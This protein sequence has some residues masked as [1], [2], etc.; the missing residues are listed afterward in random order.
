MK[1]ATL[2][3]IALYSLSTLAATNKLT[4]TKWYL[5]NVTKN[6]MTRIADT[7]CH[8]SIYF[9]ED[10]KYYGYSGMNN[11][12]GKYDITSERSL[13]MNIP[14]STRRYGPPNCILGESLYE[15]F[16]KVNRYILE[17]DHLVLFTIDS[18]RIVYRKEK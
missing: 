9:D 17:E 1:R 10:G 4:G 11:F 2:L 14:G 15:C 3:L 18:I 8:T 7:T 6:N 13:I 12:Y 5:V 16:P